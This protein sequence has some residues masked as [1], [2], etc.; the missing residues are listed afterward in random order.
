[1][2]STSSSTDH[3]EHKPEYTRTGHMTTQDIQISNS[4]LPFEV[5]E[6]KDSYIISATTENDFQIFWA[7]KNTSLNLK[8]EDTIKLLEYIKSLDRTKVYPKI[9]YGDTL[10]DQYEQIKT[11]I[12]EDSK[13]L[14]GFNPENALLQ[15]TRISGVS[16]DDVVHIE[17]LPNH[18]GKIP[19]YGLGFPRKYRRIIRAIES[20]T[21]CTAVR[22]CQNDSSVIHDKEFVLTYDDL[23]ALVDTIKRTS[24]RAQNVGTKVCDNEAQNYIRKILK[25]P[26]VAVSLGRV[27]QIKAM[28][29][30]VSESILLSSTDIEDIASRLEASR[31][32]PQDLPSHDSMMRLKVDIEI[33]S[34]DQLI[35]QYEATLNS[36]HSKKEKFWQNYFKENQFILQN[37]LAAPLDYYADQVHV[38]EIDLQGKG[39]KIVDFML[40]NPVSRLATLVEIKKPS[41]PLTLKKPYR[42]KVDSEVYGPSKDLGGGIAQLQSQIS[43]SYTS[44][45]SKIQ[46]R[47]ESEPIDLPSIDGVL[48]IGRLDALNDNQTRS[49]AS[50]RNYLHGITIVTFDEIL[51]RLTHMRDALCA[52]TP[53]IIAGLNSYQ[54]PNLT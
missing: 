38:G 27:P 29:E 39:D 18:F 53:D 15:S 11:F 36:S 35:E 40:R 1:M 54:S 52:D 47:M 26:A 7:N 32:K 33:A 14:W 8:F 49:F 28:T 2:Q 16:L 10:A 5:M 12:I 34:L 31:N 19:D 24:N 22:F 43:S 42:G 51:K 6:S 41:S 17:G 3:H 23:E 9:P 20:S 46:N 30:A 21:D 25:E 48:I 44:L 4:N 13:S 37:L 45:K 50:F